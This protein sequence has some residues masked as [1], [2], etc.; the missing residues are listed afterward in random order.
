MD[1]GVLADVMNKY[2]GNA[3]TPLNGVGEDL[4]FCWRARQCG[5][6]IVV[7]PEV[8]LGHIGHITVNRKFYES[9]KQIKEGTE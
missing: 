6:N 8:E 3:F 5:Y 2:E 7:D 4:S 9:T 1:T